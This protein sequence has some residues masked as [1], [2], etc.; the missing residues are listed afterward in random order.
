MAASATRPLPIGG[1]GK[2]EGRMSIYKMRL[3]QVRNGVSMR[4]GGG[5][6]LA[7][8]EIKSKRDTIAENIYN[9]MF[10]FSAVKFV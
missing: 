4:I 7:T 9:R 3:H 2:G 6:C 1:E 8:K 10:I 5:G